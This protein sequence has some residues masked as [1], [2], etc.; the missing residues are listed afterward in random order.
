MTNTLWGVTP[1]GTVIN[2]P[3]L[4][5]CGEFGCGKTLFGLSIAP[6]THAEG[7]PFA[8]K[9]RTL[10]IDAEKSSATYTSLPFDR[11]DVP[12]ELMKRHKGTYTT[13]QMYEWL[14]DTLQKVEPQRYDVIFI[15]PITD[16]D[17]GLTDYV[18]KN[19]TNF[20]MTPNQLQKAPGLLWGI[21]KEQWNLLLNQVATRCFTFVF[22]AHMGQVFVGGVPTPKRE[23]RGKETLM[24]LS[25]LYLELIRKPD[26]S[27]VKPAKPAGKIIKGRISEHQFDA[28]SG[29][30]RSVEL[31]PESM[32]E[33][34]PAALRMYIKTPFTGQNIVVDAPID[35]NVLLAFKADMER[36]RNEAN[37]GELEILRNKKQIMEMEVQFVN[38]KNV[39]NGSQ[40]AVADK[41]ETLPE[42][43]KKTSTAHQKQEVL[44]ETPIPPPATESTRS[45]V[46]TKDMSQAGE[47]ESP[48]KE[49]KLEAIALPPVLVD[50]PPKER[51][52]AVVKQ[53]V[54]D[55]YFSKEEYLAFLKHHNVVKLSELSYEAYDHLVVVIEH[56]KVVHEELAAKNIGFHN[57]KRFAEVV[58][59]LDSHLFMT[60]EHFT[61]LREFIAH[62]ESKDIPF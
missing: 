7:H 62:T 22:S 35:E 28:A 17:S 11:I 57:V 19:I 27:G 15:D 59:K 21:V 42:P 31:I 20:G 37:Q 52:N 23:P 51:D 58:Y 40:P 6:G 13:I 24:K 38:S 16:F 30:I 9:N 2:I 10:V 41:H 54:A 50:F 29:E 47:R 36:N 5:V 12:D 33:C 53:A 43:A 14:R 1:N 8:G 46:Q 4:G 3:T 55:E 44:A 18:K 49:K 39:A 60:P 32:P 48:T 26:K 61:K 56:L 34:T 25:S 45:V